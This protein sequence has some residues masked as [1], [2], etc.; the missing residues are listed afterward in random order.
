MKLGD[1][2]LIGGIAAGFYYLST[3]KEG[4]AS[5]EDN[6]NEDNS[7]EGNNDLPLELDSENDETGISS[8]LDEQ[9]RDLNY[10]VFE[11]ENGEI[12]YNDEAFDELAN[13]M[14]PF[15]FDNPDMYPWPQ[16]L[17]CCNEEDNTTYNERVNMVQQL[18]VDKEYFNDTPEILAYL[19]DY[20]DMYCQERQPCDNEIIGEDGRKV[21][22]NF[23]NG[24]DDTLLQG[25]DE[26]VNFNSNNAFIRE[27]S[28][29]IK[30]S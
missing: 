25:E 1:L 8:W 13:S 6:S 2:M 9:G 17:Q 30:F 16:Y 23:V 29:I 12:S 28:K 18:L 27:E 4:D 5:T 7:N 26:L 21:D 20:I 14:V 22:L 19:M 10:W 11:N 15:P 3:K 24:K